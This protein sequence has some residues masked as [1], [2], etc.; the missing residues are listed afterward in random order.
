M[1]RVHGHM[2][3]TADMGPEFVLPK[4]PTEGSLKEYH[5]E[6]EGGATGVTFQFLS[7][8]H[9]KMRLPKEI[10]LEHMRR[11]PLSAPDYFEFA[12]IRRDRKKR[13]AEREAALQS[14]KQR[15]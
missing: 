4:P 14:K 1:D 5:P 11:I 9:F 7:R 3:L 10:A 12:G 2:Y 6:V 8:D 15:C 13:R